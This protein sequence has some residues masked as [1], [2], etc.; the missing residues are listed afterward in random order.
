[1]AVSTKLTWVMVFLAS[2]PRPYICV[3]E[4]FTQMPH[5]GLRESL[6]FDSCQK[7]AAPCPIGAGPRAEEG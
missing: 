6:G 2:E 7:T 4:A 5:P 1:M 3:S